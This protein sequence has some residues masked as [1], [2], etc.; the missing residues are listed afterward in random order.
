MWCKAQ[1]QTRELSR[2]C[3]EVNDQSVKVEPRFFLSPHSPLVLF[4]G[5]GEGGDA[6][7]GTTAFLPYEK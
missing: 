4:S 7:L 3:G 6:L 5:N 1:A 2:A